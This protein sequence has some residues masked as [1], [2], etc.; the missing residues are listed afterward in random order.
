MSSDRALH[1]SLK[2]NALSGF[3]VFL[4]ALPLCLAVAKASGFPPVSGILTAIVGGLFC[5]PLGSA[6][7]TIK[8]PAAGLIVIVLGCVT[9]LGAGDPSVG[10][11]YALAVG[12]VAASLQIILAMLRA[13][14]LAIVMPPAVV[15]GMLAAIGAIIVTKQLPVM[16][17]TKARGKPLELFTQL[18]DYITQANPKVVGLGVLTASVL[19]LW[20][21]LP[22][23]RL[24]KIP[25]T[26]VALCLTVPL[27]MLLGLHEPHNYTLLGREFVTT[28]ALMVN[29]P[30]H[31]IDAL[32]L[33]D[34]SRITSITSIK[35]IVLFTLVG[36]IESLLSVLAIDALDPRAGSSDLN[37]DLFATGLG[38]L[39]SSLIGGMPMISAIVRSK[40]N[41]DAGATSPWSN[42]F[43]GVFLL[44]F[45]VL[46]PWLLT[47]IPLAVLAAMLVVIGCRLA[48]PATFKLVAS[49][50]RDQLA[51]FLTTFMLTL[52]V[53]LLLGVVMGVALNFIIHLLRGASPRQLLR[54]EVSFHQQDDRIRVV[55]EGPITFANFYPWFQKLT[56]EITSTTQRVEVDLKK[57]T[58]VDITA[59][60]R[61]YTASKEWPEAKLVLINH[62]HLKLRP[63]PAED[64]AH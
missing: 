62:E 52:G 6:P 23:K 43:H 41:I 24:E 57:V 35:Y 30:D 44:A 3:I 38:N 48:T 53:D 13:G 49:Q 14:S 33:P 20:P 17:G 12:L 34:F 29:V 4:V 45:V 27:G 28:S 8:G 36:S 2:Q 31:L 63:P 64:A 58:F 25:A 39:V 47:R 26:L 22:I 19:V 1:H 42:F 37:K 55:L 5:S 10:Y 18:P 9:E 46:L 32:V 54:A 21:K 50:G 61:L 15:R 11:P 59:T 51:I 16:L 56:R 60:D 7:L 40:A